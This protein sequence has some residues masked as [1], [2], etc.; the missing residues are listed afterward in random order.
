VSHSMAAPELCRN[1]LSGVCGRQGRK[2]TVEVQSIEQLPGVAVHHC[3]CRP[4]AIAAFQSGPLLLLWLH[5]GVARCYCC[6][7]PLAEQP[8][9]A[10]WSGVWTPCG[11]PSSVSRR[12]AEISSRILLPG[13]YCC[14]AERPVAASTAARG[15]GPSLLPL[16][17]GGATRSC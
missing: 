13:F 7:R 15:S 1:F 2:G 17:L 10:C 4:V 5:G 6:C 8:G 3:S 14:L 11:R 16:L 12:Q 9:A